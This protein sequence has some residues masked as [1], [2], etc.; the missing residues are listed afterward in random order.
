M[1]SKHI[2]GKEGVYSTTAIRRGIDN[3]PNEE[4]G[5]NT[6]AADRV[7]VTVVVEYDT[8]SIGY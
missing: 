2:S 4:Q 5:V 1:I 7:Y 8:S 6:N 3:I